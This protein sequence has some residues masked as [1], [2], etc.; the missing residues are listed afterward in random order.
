MRCTD[1]WD[2]VQD[3]LRVVLEDWAYGG[4]PA[5][6]AQVERFADLRG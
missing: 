1:H 4:S 2:L 3:Q 5:A 6:V